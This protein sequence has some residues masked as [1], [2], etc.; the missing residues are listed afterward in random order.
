MA[1]IKFKLFKNL[2]LSEIESAV[3]NWLSNNK[4]KII[5][6]QICSYS[7]AQVL[8]SIWYTYIKRRME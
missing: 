4:I 6:T 1:N 2:Y 5:N 8:V 7:D 3:N